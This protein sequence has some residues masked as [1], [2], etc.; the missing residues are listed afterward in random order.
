MIKIK[1]TK[2][3]HDF[4]NK[5][6]YLLHKNPVKVFLI[7]VAL[8]SLILISAPYLNDILMPLNQ[9]FDPT[10]GYKYQNNLMAT[11]NQSVIDKSKLKPI[12]KENVLV[13]PKI[14]VDSEIIEGTDEKTLDKGIWRKP[15]SSNPELGGNTVLTA[16]RFLYTFGPNTFYHL[17][18]IVIGDKFFIFWNQKEYDYEVFEKREVQPTEVVIEDNTV[19]PIVTLYTCT[20]NAERRIV[21]KAK[22]IFP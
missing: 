9:L 1:L 6:V 8:I 7:I 17:D 21:V 16:H 5:F 14:Q 4:P 13:I 19:E 11:D 18:K 20:K 15:D 10:K 2:I 3:Q 22:L 12:P